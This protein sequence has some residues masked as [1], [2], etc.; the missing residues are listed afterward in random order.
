MAKRC[1]CNCDGCKYTLLSHCGI[2][3]NG[4]HVSCDHK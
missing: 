1:S 3:D 2:H 4:C